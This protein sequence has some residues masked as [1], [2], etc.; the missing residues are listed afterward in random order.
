MIAGTCLMVWQRTNIPSYSAYVNKINLMASFSFMQFI[1]LPCL[2]Q[3]DSTATLVASAHDIGTRNPVSKC[4]WLQSRHSWA[5]AWR[6][7]HNSNRRGH[8]MRSQRQLQGSR[9]PG[10]LCRWRRLWVGR[11]RR[12]TRQTLPRIT[13]PL[14]D[15]GRNCTPQL[16]YETW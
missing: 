7:H 9:L 11:Q 3:S 10:P 14:P 4:L 5:S 6:G 13:W 8:Q 12:C 1:V 15:P 2:E 16:R